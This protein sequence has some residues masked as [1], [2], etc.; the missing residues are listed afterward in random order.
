MVF[1]FGN[2]IQIPEFFQDKLTIIVP[3][4]LQCLFLRQLIPQNVVRLHI[5]FSA[6]R[7]MRE[8]TRG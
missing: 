1:K 8:L 6:G 3:R 4:S 5:R 2:R 7:K